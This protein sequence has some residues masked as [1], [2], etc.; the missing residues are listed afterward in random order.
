MTTSIT[1]ARYNVIHHTPSY[2]SSLLF[3]EPAETG[4]SVMPGFDESLSIPP[5]LEPPRFDTDE[6][7][8]SQMHP[9]YPYGRP[10]SLGKKGSKGRGVGN[11]LGT[12]GSGMDMRGGEWRGRG[13]RWE[14][15]GLEDVKEKE[16]RREVPPGMAGAKR[17]PS[18][19]SPALHPSSI[20]APRSIH[21]RRLIE[22]QRSSPVIP[23]EGFDAPV[24]N[25][26]Y[27]EPQS[28]NTNHQRQGQ[29]TN[30]QQTVQIGTL[31][32]NRREGGRTSADD[33]IEASDEEGGGDV[34]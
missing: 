20:P 30:E 16:G 15:W 34:D 4:W 29:M 13:E 22:R 5:H 9:S 17:P 10:L 8:P 27:D 14:E 2:T 7:L 31:G 26:T 32:Q 3:D 6:T 25:E 12:I 18:P 11:L 28:P 23:N 33:E 19:P 21:L 24:P 1:D